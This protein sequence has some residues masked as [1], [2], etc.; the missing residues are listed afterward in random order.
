MLATI[1]PDHPGILDAL[2]QVPPLCTPLV[3]VPGCSPTPA[4]GPS[5]TSLL[6]V[7]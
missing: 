7:A 6:I 1:T 4:A 2:D 3:T 5:S